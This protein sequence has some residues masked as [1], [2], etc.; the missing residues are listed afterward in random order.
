[1]KLTDARNKSSLTLKQAADMLDVSTGH[2]SDIENG[3]KSPS[4]ELAVKIT[5]LFPTVPLESLQRKNG[6]AGSNETLAR[7]G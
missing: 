5:N 6:G 2:L 3:K 7:A 1:M 4:L